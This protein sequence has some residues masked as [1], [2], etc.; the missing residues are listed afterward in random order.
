MPGFQCAQCFKELHVLY[1]RRIS[2]QYTKLESN[3]NCCIDTK[4]LCTYTLN[5]EQ[6][7]TITRTPPQGT[8]G[9][10]PRASNR[11]LARR[12]VGSDSRSRRS[13]RAVC[14]GVGASNT[15]AGSK[16]QGE[17]SGEKGNRTQSVRGFPKFAYKASPVPNRGPLSV[18]EQ[19]VFLTIRKKYPSDALPFF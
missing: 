8:E 14:C 5:H 17:V 3:R 1:R 13:G 18:R 9:N 4:L 2:C 6:G 19:L 12:S 10:Q 11:T 16:A 15:A 7:K